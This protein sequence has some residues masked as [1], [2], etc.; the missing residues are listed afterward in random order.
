MMGET[1]FCDLLSG[2]A[3][4][5][6]V[7]L[8]KPQ[9]GA[10]FRYH[11][12][13]LNA[14]HK[15]NLIRFKDELDLVG[16]HYLDSLVIVPH[17]PESVQS[18]VDVGAGAGLP[19]IPMKIARESLE[20]TLVESQAKKSKFV[21]D[22]LTTL[23]LSGTRVLCDRSENL[24][25]SEKHRESYDLAV[26]RALAPMAVACEMCLPLVRVGGWFAVYKSLGADAE[27]QAALPAIQVLGGVIQERIETRVP[28]ANMTTLLVVV[29]K[30][31]ETP[32]EFPRRP[33][34][35]RKRPL[36]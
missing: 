5:L 9:T 29:S 23:D 2:N 17:I 25:R 12:M 4:L 31:E 14:S 13:L 22:S 11:R 26:T 24:G 3:V 30:L 33:G 18:V 8:T 32:G 7:E 36:S 1:E 16:R 28:V 35:A 19:G 20:L 6:G 27:I 34:V 15:M 10:F 21:A